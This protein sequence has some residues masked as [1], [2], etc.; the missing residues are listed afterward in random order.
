MVNL[1]Q[2]RTFDRALTQYNDNLQKYEQAVQGRAAERARLAY[3]ADVLRTFRISS[4]GI[5]N[6]DIWFNIKN[7]VMVQAEFNLDAIQAGKNSKVYHI[8]GDQRAVIPY[9]RGSNSEF[10]YDPNETNSLVVITTDQ[11]VSVINNEEFDRTLADGE[12][13]LVTFNFG[14]EQDFQ[15]VEGL[16]S[17]LGI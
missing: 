15:G 17:V 9:Y 6:C 3:E 1:Y 5:F 13:D 2:G 16:V 7:P 10:R 8:T 14:N 11:K 12:Q 4:F